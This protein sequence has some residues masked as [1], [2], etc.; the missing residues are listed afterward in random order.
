MF[1]GLGARL[2]WGQQVPIVLPPPKEMLFS[3]VEW[4]CGT[5]LL[6]FGAWFW[7]Y[8]EM[9]WDLPLFSPKAWG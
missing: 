4:P 7:G 6:G 9:G 5:Q 1:A 3:A 8:G 2:G